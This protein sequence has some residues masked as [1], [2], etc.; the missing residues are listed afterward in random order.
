MGKSKRLTQIRAGRLVTAVLYTQAMAGDEAPVRAAK[1]KVSSAARQ[2]LNARASWQ[3]CEALMAANF[4]RDD[5]F[6]TLTYRDEDLPRTREEAQRRLSAFLRELRRVRAARG[7]E[8]RYIKTTEHLRDDGSE[9]RWHHHLVI[10]ATGAD[11]E[12]IRSLWTWGD[13]L[14]MDELLS[15]GWDYEARARYICKERPPVGKQAWTPSRNLRRPER[16]SELV[17]DALTLAAPAGAQILDRHEEKNA[18]GEYV[19]IKYLLPWRPKKPKRKR[20]PRRQDDP[21]GS[22]FSD[23]G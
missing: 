1:A 12:E 10:N 4:E 17:D 19:Y 22:L 9:G 13:N 11:Y 3:K 16:R 14:D 18:W 7:E 23:L 21:Y 5:L 2:K 6:L 20:M 8:L 15:Q